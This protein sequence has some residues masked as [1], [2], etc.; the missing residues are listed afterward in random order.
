MLSGGYIPPACHRY[1]GQVDIKL[2][3][4][5]AR[6]GPSIVA[7]TDLQLRTLFWTLTCHYRLGPGRWGGVF[8]IYLRFIVLISW[9]DLC[10]PPMVPHAWLWHQWCWPAQA[11]GSSPYQQRVKLRGNSL[12]PPPNMRICITWG[13]LHSTALWYIPAQNMLTIVRRCQPSTETAALG[14][15]IYCWHVAADFYHKLV[16]NY[17]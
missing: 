11:G 16:N 5:P 10:A 13:T 6:P 3:F 4:S 15:H 12:S 8:S 2:S 1:G 14:L 17:N 7:R 9:A